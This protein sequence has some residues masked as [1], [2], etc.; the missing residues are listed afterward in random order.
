[1]PHVRGLSLALVLV[2][3]TALSAEAGVEMRHRWVYVSVNM[4][5]DK[6]V[7]ST[8]A[9]IERA[10]RCG[11]NGIVLTDSKFARWDTLPH[12]YLRNVTRVREACRGHRLAV[13]ACVMPMGYAN[14]IL[15]RDPNL[16]AGLPVRD[17]PFVMRNG[18]LVPD[19]ALHV[20]NGGFE[21]FKSNRPT[22]W[23][24]LD[25]PGRICFIDTKTF[26]EGKSS[27]RVQDMAKHDPKHGH[28][29]LHQKLTLKP[30]RFYHAS[31]MV[32]TRDLDT[33]C[34]VQLTVLAKGRCLVFA[35]QKVKPTQDW[36]RVHVT[37]NTLDQT[38]G[39]LYLGVW[40]GK[41]G[42]LWFDDVR[43]E[44]AG[45]TNVVRRDGAPLRITS[46]DGAT[47]YEEGKDFANARDPKLGRR[48]WTGDF[49][50]WHEP[51]LMRV[52]PGSRL[53]EGQR[54]LA[55]YYHTL[56]IHD[57]QAMC[58][59]SE[60]KLYD[61][62]EWQLKEIKK[63]VQPDGYFMS[64]DEIRIQGW[65]ASCVKLNLTPGQILADNVKRCVALI[66]KA[67]PGKPIYVWSDMFDPFH[68][69][70]KTGTY[71]LVK[72]TGPWHGSWEGLDKDVTIVN[73]HGRKQGRVESLK[74]FAGRGHKQILA[75]YYDGPPERI[76]DWLADAAQVDGVI[77][78]MYTTWRRRFDDLEAFAGEL[79]RV[80]SR[81]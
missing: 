31:A 18:K 24:F 29:R 36:T 68:N 50:S 17:A 10:A 51:P 49:D 61:L 70:R 25:K 11:Y 73:W 65:D 77:G 46:E 7:E 19:D 1:M 12:R 71:Y 60:P 41:T 15:G 20:V 32:K 33:R 40:R 26:F 59:M 14:G 34:R 81:R 37:F 64:H 78:V 8:L 30:F 21:Q 52:P 67:D 43:V 35:D 56:L 45:L 44:P 42:A 75:G 4:L 13:N 28:G 22:G 6:N 66:R 76:R 69:A 63:H 54:V 72:G 74:H 2:L 55:S 53:R 47:A 39:R 57:K 27:L 9:V 79:G 62:L 48:R 38:E 3:V 16:A 80:S 58:C 5:V 23:S